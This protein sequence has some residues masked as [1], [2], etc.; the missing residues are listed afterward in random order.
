MASAPAT[1]DQRFIQDLANRLEAAERRFLMPVDKITLRASDDPD[2]KRLKDI[3]V[4]IANTV[5]VADA[6]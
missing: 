4:D 5:T 6:T 1:Y 3:T 2:H